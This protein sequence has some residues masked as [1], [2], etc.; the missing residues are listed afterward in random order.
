MADFVHLHKLI[1]RRSAFLTFLNAQNGVELEGGAKS[2]R[3]KHLDKWKG[4]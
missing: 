4:I 1:T 2:E 3:L